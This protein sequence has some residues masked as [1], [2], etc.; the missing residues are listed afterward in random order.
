MQL[1]PTDQG[2]AF[3]LAPSKAVTV[4]R[5]PQFQLTSARVSRQHVKLL[6][7]A[8]GNSVVVTAHKRIEVVRNST[9]AATEVQA[10]QTLQVKLGWVEQCN[11]SGCRA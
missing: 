2:V 5:Q 10:G 8:D 9:G 4:G 1:T 11:V 7:P 6:C 3:H